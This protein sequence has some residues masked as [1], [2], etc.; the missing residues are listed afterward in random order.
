MHVVELPVTREQANAANTEEGRFESYI[1]DL[2]LTPH[3]FAGTIL[4]VGDTGRF[5]NHAKEHGLSE[6]IFSVD[7]ADHLAAKQKGV[8][9]DA[10]ALPFK[11]GAFD[12]VISHYLA[13]GYADGAIIN[14]MMRVAHNI[15]KKQYE[16]LKAIL[17]SLAVEQGL[18]IEEVPKEVRYRKDSNAKMHLSYFRII[19][20]T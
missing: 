6:N 9:A 13:P 1:E 17:D 10:A 16:S 19:K 5:A 7:I 2:D 14:E 18:I 8:R 12:L 4:N 11:D 15:L 20:P 3:D